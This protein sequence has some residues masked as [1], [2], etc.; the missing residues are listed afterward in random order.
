MKEQ[1]IHLL[2]EQMETLI[3]NK[4]IPDSMKSTTPELNELQKTISY[5]SDCLKEANDFLMNLSVGKLE[6]K[7]P[8][9]HNYLATNLKELHSG[10][11]HLT[12]Q[13]NQV[14]NGDYKQKVSFLGDFSASFNQMVAQLEERESTLKNQADALTKSMNLMIAIMDGLRDW[15]IVTEMGT[16]DLLYSNHSSNKQFY[17]ADTQQ[18]ACHNENCGL[19]EHLRSCA[20]TNGE[21]RFEFYCPTNG[22][23]LFAKTFSVQWNEKRAYVHF[24]SDI[25][26]GEVKKKQL[27]TLAFRDELTGLYNR[28]HGLQVLVQLMETQ[29]GFSICLVD[30]DGLKLVNDEL[31]HLIGDDYITTV[32]GT[33]QQLPY[34]LGTLCRVGGDEFLA[35]LPNY[36]KAAALEL[37]NQLDQKL[38]TIEKNYVIAVSYG[39]VFVPRN[40][41]LQPENVLKLVDEQMYLAKKRKKRLQEE[42]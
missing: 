35:I 6:V 33:M 5:L 30:I 4:P 38:A 14:A 1:D 17:H 21:T 8:K 15:V 3:L 26:E 9:R 31:G 20:D 18:M 10:L 34:G 28:R 36:S 19:M 41:D 42:K 7:T 40:T 11:R 16:G 24:I 25:T 13:A 39:V 2:Q 12:W 23:T 29:K 22:K 37:M 27:E 32:T